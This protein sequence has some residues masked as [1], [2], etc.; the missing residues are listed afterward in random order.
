MQKIKS[1]NEENEYKWYVILEGKASY[2]QT[3]KYMQASLKSILYFLTEL[4]LF[5]KQGYV[6]IIP[7]GFVYQGPNVFN[8][9]LSLTPLPDGW[10]MPIPDG[11]IDLSVDTNIDQKLD[12]YLQWVASWKFLET[13]VELFGPVSCTAM[14]IPNKNI[15]FFG[16]IHNNLTVHS[17]MSHEHVQDKWLEFFT[18]RVQKEEDIASFKAIV[19]KIK[20]SSLLSQEPS[21]QMFIWEFIL[22]ILLSNTNECID[23]IVEDS[24][25]SSVDFVKPS[26]YLEAIRHLFSL[27]PMMEFNDSPFRH[28]V[29]A[30]QELYPNVRYHRIDL[31]FSINEDCEGEFQ[32]GG[33]Q[34]VL[35]TLLYLLMVLTEEKNTLSEKEILQNDCVVALKENHKMNNENDIKVLLSECTRM[36]K[37]FRKSSLLENVDL[38]AQAFTFSALFHAK[39]LE[40][41]KRS[42]WF[43][44]RTCITDIY[45]LSRLFRQTMTPL[46][47]RYPSQQP[48]EICASA[49][50]ASR[51]AIVYV[52]EY[53]AKVWKLFCQKMFAEDEIFIY[54][55]ETNMKARTL[56]LQAFKRK[57]LMDLQWENPLAVFKNWIESDI[58]ESVAMQLLSM[59]NVSTI[60]KFYVPFIASK[61]RDKQTASFYMNVPHYVNTL[62]AKQHATARMCPTTEDVLQNEFD[63]MSIEEIDA[64]YVRNNNCYSAHAMLALWIANY[65]DW[66]TFRDPLTRR[67]ISEND[68][69]NIITLINKNKNVEEHVMKPIRPKNPYQM[70]LLFATT[71][72]KMQGNDITFRIANV[73][74]VMQKV[75][76]RLFPFDALRNRKTKKELELESHLFLLT[77]VHCKRDVWEKVQAA[78]I[79]FMTF[80]NNIM[81]NIDAGVV[82]H[83]GV[84]FNNFQD[85]S[86]WMLDET[87]EIDKS[88]LEQFKYELSPYI[89]FDW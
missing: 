60:S 67:I 18:S 17:R 66:K 82:E 32:N 79:D 29:S 71:R 80:A 84:H 78:C 45:G 70:E 24:L 16:D 72:R 56:K 46:F 35:S 11:S 22:Q 44:L 31:R 37:A 3:A 50:A 30:C 7:E 54:V 20:L 83:S 81:F 74:I 75:N 33:M 77:M 9:S 21:K 4:R 49:D 68:Q 38:F 27:C 1:K 39:D 48:S 47:E 87:L 14:N 86:T 26:N 25:Q 41:Q 43:T 2:V 61:T 51:K 36:A 12:H 62:V 19:Q 63:H 57:P 23:V 13:N 64:V 6:H 40:G 42:K 89:T 34:A 8:E 5:K 65:K 76:G 52:G 28:Q 69:E 88:R 53:H 15:V 10:Q 85:A 73:R 55:N 58:K 59:L